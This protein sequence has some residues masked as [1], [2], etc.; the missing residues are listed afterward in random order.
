MAIDPADRK[1]YPTSGAP[2]PY[3]SVSL[4]WTDKPTQT[5]IAPTYRSSTGRQTSTA[6]VSG[7]GFSYS[8]NLP[9]LSPEMLAALMARRGAATSRFANV[10]SEARRKQQMSE[11]NAIFAKQESDRALSQQRRE[12]MAT[13]AGRGVAR[14]PIFA[15][16]LRQQIAQEGARAY[17]KIEMDLATT[18]EELRS[19]TER[20]RVERDLEYAQIEFDTAMARSAAGRLA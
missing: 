12:G 8:H 6:G 10:E 3:R 13:L 19:A 17:A 18:I 1:F 15:N 14:A 16:P 4:P 5:Y 20:A 2:S 11:A 9:P 7:G